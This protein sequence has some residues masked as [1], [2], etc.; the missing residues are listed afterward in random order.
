MAFNTTHSSNY[1]SLLAISIH[2]IVRNFNNAFRA[3]LT[4]QYVSRRIFVLSA[5]KDS[6]SILS[7]NN[8]KTALKVVHSV[9]L[10]VNV[11]SVEILIL[12]LMEFVL[13]NAPWWILIALNVTQ[14]RIIVLHVNQMNL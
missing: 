14:K 10:Q 5:K 9:N 3:C 11:M 13:R 6:F 2:I 8:A 1:V 7:K 12:I 4:A